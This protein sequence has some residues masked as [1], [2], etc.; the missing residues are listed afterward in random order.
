MSAIAHGVFIVACV[1]L[2]WYRVECF[3]CEVGEI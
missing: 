2:I 1:C 3:C